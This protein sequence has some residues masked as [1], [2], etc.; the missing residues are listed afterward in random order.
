MTTEA[1]NVDDGIAVGKETKAAAVVTQMENTDGTMMVALSLSS[2]RQT[3][4]KPLAYFLRCNCTAGDDQDCPGAPVDR[5][6]LEEESNRVIV[7]LDVSSQPKVPKR[8][9]SDPQAP[10]RL[11]SLSSTCMKEQLVTTSPRTVDTSV[12]LAAAPHCSQHGST[13]GSQ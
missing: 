1:S 6:L 8:K 3:L 10:P 9:T 11:P 4:P 7:S 13:K 2:S 12:T 5:E